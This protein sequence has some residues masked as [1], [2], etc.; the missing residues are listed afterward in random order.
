MA[1]KLI[2]FLY[3]VEDPFNIRGD[4]DVHLGLASLAV[5]NSEGDDPKQIPRSDLR[6]LFPD[7][8]PTSRVA[9]TSRFSKL[10]TGTN[11]IIFHVE[12]ELLTT[13]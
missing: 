11:L 3:F 5:G 7:D 10:S 1:G 4:S 6:L 8:Q 13:V 2:I 12:A 9:I